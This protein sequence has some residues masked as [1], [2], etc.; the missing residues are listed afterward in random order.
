MAIDPYPIIDRGRRAEDLIKNETLAEVLAAMEEDATTRW[1]ASHSRDIDGREVL[2]HQV[3]A[4]LT[5]K[6][7]LH[8][9]VESAK[10]EAAKLEKIEMRRARQTSGRDAR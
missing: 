5:L 10:A 1:L 9:W 2:Y 8:S 3:Q 4:I 7:T 6:A